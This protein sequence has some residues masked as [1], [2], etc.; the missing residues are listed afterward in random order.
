M[1]RVLLV[2]DEADQR[3]LYAVSLTD[4]GFDVVTAKNGSE[5]LKM[6]AENQPD[7]V[8]LDIQMPGMDGIEALGHLLAKNKNVVLLFYSAYPAFKGNFMTWA[9][10]AFV[11]KTGDP[12]EMVNELRRVLAERGIMTLHNPKNVLPKN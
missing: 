12:L 8:V 5:A 11:I 6:F 4:E 10:D 1:P 7:A 9:A 3:N 2:E